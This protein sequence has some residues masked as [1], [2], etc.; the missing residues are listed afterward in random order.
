MDSFIVAEEEGEIL[1]PSSILNSNKPQT[2][3]M[4]NSDGFI[5]CSRMD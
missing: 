1:I 5:A 2:E 4:T 3:T